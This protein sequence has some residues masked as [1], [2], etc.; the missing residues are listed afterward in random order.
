MAKPQGA[1]SHRW[2]FEATPFTE[3]ETVMESDTEG[4]GGR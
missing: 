1:G 4:G 3:V 2:T